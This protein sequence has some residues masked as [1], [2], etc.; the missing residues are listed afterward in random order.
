MCLRSRKVSFS[1]NLLLTLQF[2]VKFQITNWGKKITKRTSWVINW[3][4]FGIKNPG[5]K[6]NRSV[7]H[8]ISFI[9]T[10]PYYSIYTGLKKKIY[11]K[12]YIEITEIIIVIKKKN[13][14]SQKKITSSFLHRPSQWLLN[15]KV[16]LG[17]CSFKSDI[18][19]SS[20]HL[21]S[22]AHKA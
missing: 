1:Q 19:I 16:L 21:W 22:T 15:I 4:S 6:Y 5:K 11:W 9:Q 10:L 8:S 3:G 13:I 7:I 12:S 17:Y 14:N 2:A 20:K 18:V